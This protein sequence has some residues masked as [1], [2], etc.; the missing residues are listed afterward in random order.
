MAAH[1]TQLIGGKLVRLTLS[2]ANKEVERATAVFQ[3]NFIN[4]DPSCYTSKT[5]TFTTYSQGMRLKDDDEKCIECLNA[6]VANYSLAIEKTYSQSSSYYAPVIILLNVKDGQPIVIDNSVFVIDEPL[7]LNAFLQNWNEAG[8][9]APEY[10]I[11][12]ISTDN[13]FDD[14]VG[15]CLKQDITVIVNPIYDSNKKLITGMIFK[16]FEEIVRLRD[17]SS[18]SQKE[19]P[20]SQ[21]RHET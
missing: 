12:I 3:K 14:F 9:S 7:N 2:S 17:S 10:A 11:Q 6:E 19:P 4:G 16:D 13:E 5:G 15:R 18:A 1:G 21:P 20:S 8:I